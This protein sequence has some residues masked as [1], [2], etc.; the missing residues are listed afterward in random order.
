[1]VIA[2]PIVSLLRYES[3][4]RFA[5]SEEH[6]MLARQA[7]VHETKDSDG[8]HC[9]WNASS[10][11][12]LAPVDKPPRS[13]AIVA[14]ALIAAVLAAAVELMGDAG[15]VCVDTVNKAALVDEVVN[16]DIDVDAEVKLE[17]KKVEKAIALWLIVVNTSSSKAN[18]VML[19]PVEQSQ[20]IRV[21]L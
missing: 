3:V 16:T 11:P 21:P 13:W 20:V 15:D 18:A 1:M 4:L 8:N 2:S 9:K 5:W 19:N 12:I 17:V 10:K 6:V 7:P 14:G